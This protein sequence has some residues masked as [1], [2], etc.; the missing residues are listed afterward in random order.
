MRTLIYT[1][2]RGLNNL[3]PATEQSGFYP[4]RM[5]ENFGSEIHVCPHFRTTIIDFINFHKNRNENYDFVF[6]HAGVVDFAP[7]RQSRCWAIYNE[8]KSHFDNVFGE[9]VIKE[10]LSSTFNYELKGE[11]TTNMYSLSMANQYVLPYLK[12]IDNL[13]WI[14][15]SRIIS[16]LNVDTFSIK[17]IKKYSDYFASQLNTIDLSKWD[18]H[19]L[20]KCTIPDQIHLSRRGSNALYDL[21]VEEMEK[22]L[23]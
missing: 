21:M 22:K 4:Q 5:K 9:L 11:I 14:N 8:R 17:I 13:L 19:Q 12:K 6:L 16:N 10:H 20:R 3:S 23:K 2:S 18:D 1:D 15:C 7:R